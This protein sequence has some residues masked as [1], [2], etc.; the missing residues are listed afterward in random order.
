MKGKRALISGA[1]K[2]GGLGQSFALAAG[3][4]GAESV[5]V[6]GNYAYITTGYGLQIANVVNP[7][8]PTE[9][10]RFESTGALQEVAVAGNYAYA[11]SYN[12]GLH[13]INVANPAAPVEVGHFDTPVSALAVFN[14]HAYVQYNNGLLVTIN[15]A[16]PAVPVEVATFAPPFSWV[17]L[18]VS[19]NY[20][21]LASYWDGLLIISN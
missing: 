15:V 1:G 5:A 19:G 14:H 12:T 3:L 7:A 10:A 4:N 8:A 20:V 21:Y 2:D 17:G 9:V 11:T 6:A 13:I 18:T 16:N